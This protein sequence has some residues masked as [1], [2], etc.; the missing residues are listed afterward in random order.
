MSTSLE[1][2]VLE[3]ECSLKRYRMGLTG[4]VVALLVAILASAGPLFTQGTPS[5][6][7]VQCERLTIR[8]GGSGAP[9]IEIWAD[10][11][12]AH[13]SMGSKG[14]SGWISLDTSSPAAGRP[15][16]ASLSVRTPRGEVLINDGHISG[17]SASAPMWFLGETDGRPIVLVFDKAGA[18]RAALK[19]AEV[20]SGQVE[21]L[22]GSGGRL[23][24]TPESK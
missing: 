16:G 1:M 19:I 15:A 18:P 11:E 17:V 5:S 24:L 13:L 22:N 2:R 9:A 20:G 7:E 12:G 3:L 8:T 10:E 14:E 21:L 23:L 4:I 6:H